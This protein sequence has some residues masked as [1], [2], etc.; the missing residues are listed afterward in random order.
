MA[1]T[2]HA[3]RD[4]AIRTIRNLTMFH[5]QDEGERLARAKYSDI[6]KGT[7]SGWL[8]I[9]RLPAEPPSMT[10][11][12]ARAPGSTG[13][14]AAPLSFEERIA[15]M[16]RQADMIAAQ[17]MTQ[18][19]DPTTGEVTLKAK[20]LAMLAQAVR[21]QASAAELLVKYAQAAWNQGR[22]EELYQQVIDAIGEVDRGLQQAVLARLRG[23]NER[24]GGVANLG[25][26][27]AP[28]TEAAD[29]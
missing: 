7:F 18:V 25:I 12:A 10:L 3:A 23:L 22:M 1:A 26:G 4:E 6:A 8:K 17:C 11:P 21:L 5:G 9:A 24:R 16:D 14:D 29:F 28:I 20:N 27:V 15:K 13:G 19:T 2:P